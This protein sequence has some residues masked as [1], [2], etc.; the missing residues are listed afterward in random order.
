MGRS[1]YNH[2][3]FHIHTVDISEESYS[4]LLEYTNNH[5]MQLG[6]CKCTIIIDPLTQIMLF[7][8]PI[9]KPVNLN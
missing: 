9:G 4:D 6:H 3:D 8:A 7:N 1:L 2:N 5:K